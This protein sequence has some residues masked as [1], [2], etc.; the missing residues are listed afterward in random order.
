M[1]EVDTWPF[2]D[3][4]LQLGSLARL[5]RVWGSKDSMRPWPIVKLL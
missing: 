5:V 2:S 1:Q 3:V 4:S